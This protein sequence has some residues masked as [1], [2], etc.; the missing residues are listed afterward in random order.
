ML[1]FPRVLMDVTQA[2][3]TAPYS[4]IAQPSPSLARGPSTPQLD[5]SLDVLLPQGEGLLEE[6]LTHREKEEPVTPACLTP[7]ILVQWGC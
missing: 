1:A 6:R 3:S 4:G 7:T 2:H 5:E